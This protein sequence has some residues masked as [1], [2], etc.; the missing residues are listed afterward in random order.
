MASWIGINDIL[1]MANFQLPVQG[2][3]TFEE[4]FTAVIAEQFD[5]LETVYDAG[6]RNFLFLNLPPLDKTV[7]EPS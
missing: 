7:R 5:A 2:L 1:D 4:F 3:A 6:F